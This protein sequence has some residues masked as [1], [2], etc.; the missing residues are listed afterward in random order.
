[1]RVP[2]A[3]KVIREEPEPQADDELTAEGES[4]LGAYFGLGAHDEPTSNQL[5]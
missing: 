5:A 2:Y 4:I 1:V 3:T